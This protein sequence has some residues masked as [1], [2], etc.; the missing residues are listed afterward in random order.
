MRETPQRVPYWDWQQREGLPSVRGLVIEDLNQVELASWDRTGGRGAF[1]DLGVQRGREG[2]GWVCEIPSGGSLN[3]LH[4]MFDEAIYVT[5][6]R[7]AT[8]FWVEGK[9]K[10]MV[11]W[12]HRP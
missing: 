7:G 6:G 4:H 3:P 8:T 1:T 10:Q 5:E 12:R 2:G 9:G 11:E